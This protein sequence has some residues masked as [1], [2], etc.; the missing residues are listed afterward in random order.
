MTTIPIY[1]ASVPV[2]CTAGRDEI[3]DR[4]LQLERLRDHLT[5][6]ERTE[7]GML[8][9]LPNRPDVDAELRAFAVDEKGCCAFWGFAVT[10]VGDELTL[11]WDGPPEV[12]ELFDRL[13]E[14][15]DGD[16]PLTAFDGLL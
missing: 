16:Q 3:A 6:L 12:G 5:G 15:F 9:H 11:R 1:D 14:F 7:H 4:I 13:V 8:L 2:A 10:S